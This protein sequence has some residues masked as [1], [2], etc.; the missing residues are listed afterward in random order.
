M[1]PFETFVPAVFLF[2]VDFRLKNDR[3]KDVESNIHDYTTDEISPNSEERIGTTNIDVNMID[4]NVKGKNRWNDKHS[5][6]H[7]KNGK[8]G[9]KPNLS[10]GLCLNFS[11]VSHFHLCSFVC[12]FVCVFVC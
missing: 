2:C 1:T 4:D 5:E 8:C 3:K 6:P 7:Q 10:S 12:L 9:K 11:L